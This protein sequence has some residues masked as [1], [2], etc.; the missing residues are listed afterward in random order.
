MDR[1][2]PFGALLSARLPAGLQYRT[3]TLYGLLALIA[4]FPRLWMIPWVGVDGSDTLYY[5]TLASRWVEGDFVFRVEGGIAVFRPVLISLHALALTVFGGQDWSV[6]AL[7]A[8]ADTATIVLI[9]VTI[10]RHAGAGWLITSVASLLYAL[11]PFIVM[12][13][14][15]ELATPISGVFVTSAFLVFLEAM[16]ATTRRR[17][18]GGLALAGLICGLS[19]GVHEELV[20]IAGGFCA[21]LGLRWG[22]HVLK[23][24]KISGLGRLIVQLGI[25]GASAALPALWPFFLHFTDTDAQLAVAGTRATSG[26]DT[27][28]WL[29]RIVRYFWNASAGA[30]SV[31]TVA[32]GVGLVVGL[33]SMRALGLVRRLRTIEWAPPVI[34]LSLLVPFA[35]AF[36]VIFVRNFVP[37]TPLVIIGFAAAGHRLSHFMPTASRFLQIA[38]CSAAL[39]VILASHLGQMANVSETLRRN[40]VDTWR[41]GIFLQPEQIESGLQSLKDRSYTPTFYRQVYDAVHASGAVD[42]QVLIAASVS[43]PYPGRRGFDLPFYFGDRAVFLIDEHEPV[44]QLIA[45]HDIRTMIFTRFRARREFMAPAAD[46]RC[47]A[48]CVW[49]EGRRSSLGL[50]VGLTPQSY[51]IDEERTALMER[52]EIGA[53]NFESIELVERTLS[54][55]P[56]SFARLSETSL[57]GDGR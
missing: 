14:R 32:I 7:N 11:S 29:S 1:R 46:G 19:A 42:G 47:K 33:L 24:R 44:E 17:R 22:F 8:L 27:F 4:L 25:I 10:R 38:G 28:E 45:R 12:L 55:A 3:A 30:Y 37:L 31:P 13:S 43:S 23:I 41:L 56:V 6:K 51:S 57:P 53:G 34:I 50:P 36:P 18:L 52:L 35:L 9:A 54:A 40:Y 20:L 16:R 21:V 5:L 39:A 48:A 49:R 2:T 15:M 26:I